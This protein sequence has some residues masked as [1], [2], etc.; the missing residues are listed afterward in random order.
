[1]K[2]RLPAQL[3]GWALTL[4][5]LLMIAAFILLPLLASIAVSFTNYSLTRP[6]IAW[7]GL[8]NYQDLLI[9]DGAAAGTFLA[10]LRN[11]L[12][13]GIVSVGIEFVLGFILALL[14]YRV[15]KGSGILRTLLVLPIMVAPAVSALQWRW[16]LDPDNGI[17]NYFGL[18]L[19]LLDR[20]Q[21]WLVRPAEAIWTV[22]L[23]DVWQT[24][25]FVLLFLPEEPYEAARVD[26]A[27]SLQ[28]FRWLT[29]PLLR[30]VILTVLLLRFMDAFRIFDIVYVLTR[31][32][33]AFATDMVSLY[34]Y[35]AGLQWFEIGKASAAAT[36]TLIL[37][38]LCAAVLLRF[39]GDSPADRAG[40]NA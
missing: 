38:A 31:G 39:L 4:P 6:G 14:L 10:A 29:L 40:D 11:S 21:L 24:T 3:A 16:I 22:V 20:P 18:Q 36:L 7:V 30:P 5:A 15:T 23:V 35:R 33:P 13:F 37:I 9:G 19:G 34:T 27:S 26:G 25:P 2:I 1:M 12:I 8:K 28:I 17:L 32:G